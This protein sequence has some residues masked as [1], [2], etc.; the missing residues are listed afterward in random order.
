MII[1]NINP[2]ALH[3]G[4][5]ELHWYGILFA[6]GLLIAY[7]L[8]EWIFKKEGVDTKLL[9]PLFF[10]IVVG[11][12]VGARL[13]HVIFYDPIYFS[14]H[15]LEILEVW[16]GGLASHGGAIG[17]IVAVIIFSKK[18]KIDFWWLIARAMPSTFALALV[19]K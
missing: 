7:F 5:I 10:Y 6:S 16:R 18:Y 11:I 12:V 8:G 19:Q 9:E 4:Q 1:W 17:A 14:K 13:F 3:I 2:I 15:P